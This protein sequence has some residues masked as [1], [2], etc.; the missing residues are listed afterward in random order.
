MR[1]I[2]PRLPF[3]EIRTLKQDVDDSLWA[4]RTLA[5]I[6]SVF[7][8]VAALVAC[9]GLYGL[10]SFTLAQ[11]RKEIGIRMALGAGPR[12]IARVTLLRALL[13]VAAGAAAGLAISLATARLMRSLLYGV[14]PAAPGGNLA[15]VAIILLTGVLAAALPAWRAS[16]VDPAETLRM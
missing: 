12:E 1:R 7:S 11:R 2:D 6:G 14:T 13:L 16:R 3:R 9:I 5:G 4:E 10:L 15:A 8:A